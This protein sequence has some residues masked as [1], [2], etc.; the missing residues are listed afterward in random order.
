MYD[1]CLFKYENGNLISYKNL[2]ELYK[3]EKVKAI[4]QINSNEY[5]L[6]SQKKGVVYGTN[7]Y[8]IFYDMITD[9]KIKSLKIGNGERYGNLLLLNKENLIV[10]R[11]YSLVLIDVKNRKT[12]KNTINNIINHILYIFY[13]P[14]L[15]YWNTY[16]L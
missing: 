11:D 14:E 13:S 3:K 16:N 8:I 1:Q 6:L 7:D 15:Q 9:K 5:A 4:A 2:N 12:N 10:F